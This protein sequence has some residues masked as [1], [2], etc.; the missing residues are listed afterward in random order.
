MATKR[1]ITLSAI[2]SLAAEAVMG[3]GLWLE[4]L[5]RKLMGMVVNGMGKIRSWVLFP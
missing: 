1:D 4:P 2:M 3:F 5:K